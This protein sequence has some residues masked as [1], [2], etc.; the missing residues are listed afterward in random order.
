MGAQEGKG[1]MSTAKQNIERAKG[2][3][4]ERRW[5]RAEIKAIIKLYGGK[6]V[7]L[8]TVLQ[9]LAERDKTEGNSL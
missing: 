5:L 2:A 1:G 7:V 9:K 3:A 4:A 6:D 8:E